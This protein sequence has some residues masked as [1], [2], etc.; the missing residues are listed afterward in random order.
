MINAPEAAAGPVPIERPPAPGTARLV[1]SPQWCTESGSPTELVL[2]A[3]ADRRAAIDGLAP[4]HLELV[5]GWSAGWPVEVPAGVGPLIDRLVEIGAL[6]PETAAVPAIGLVGT[7]PIAS[8][9]AGLVTAARLVPVTDAEVVLMVR[10]GAGWPTDGPPLAAD[11][12]QLGIDLAF[13]H[14]VVIG[15]LVVPG[16]SACLACLDAR[17]DGFWDRAGVPAAPGVQRW[18]PAIAALVDVQLDLIGQGRSPLVNATA[19]WDLERAAA[20][21]EHLYRMTGCPSCQ[22]TPVPPRV[23]LQWAP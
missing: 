2:S 15:P 19:T 17:V 18:L 20:S 4:A 11:Q 23:S 7:D 6:R 13:H 3:G 5:A 12:L 22:P 9:L 10:T 8:E 14:T 16:A 1:W 21:V